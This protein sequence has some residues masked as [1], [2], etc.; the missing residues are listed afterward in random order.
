M[1]TLLLLAAASAAATPAATSASTSQ[2][3]ERISIYATRQPQRIEQVNASVNV[4][5]R[6]E[7]DMR[8]PK[9]LPAL[10]QSLPGVEVARQGSRGQT[11]SIFIRGSGSKYVLVLID[12]MRV[13]SATLGYMDLSQL[14]LDAIEQI[15][16]IRGPRAALYGSDAVSGV[17][18]ITT[19]KASGVTLSAKVASQGLAETSLQGA[20]TIDQTQL[21]AQ[22]GYGRA[23]GIHVLDKPGVDTDRD[24][25]RNRFVRSGLTQR[26]TGGDIS[27]QSQLNRGYNQFDFN[28][29]WGLGA[30]QAKT[31]QDQHQLSASYQT[32]VGTVLKQVSTQVK[33]GL[34]RDDSLTYGN[35]ASYRYIT[36]RQELDAQSLLAFAGD[37]DWLIGV[38]RTRDEVATSGDAYVRENR[39]S[40]SAFTAVS[41]Q[42][43]ALHLDTALRHDHVSA[44]DSYQTYQWGASYQ[45]TESL[46][47]R[48]NQGSS[49]KVPTYNDLYYP[50]FGN[51]DLQ[52]ET[53]LSREAGVRFTPQGKAQVTIDAVHFQRNLSNMIAY[54]SAVW[55]SQN[56]AAAELTGFEYT[57]A[58][59]TAL[60]G[61]DI[62]HEL[63]ATYTDGV[64]E[65]TKNRVLPNIP[66]QKYQYQFSTERG[67]WQYQG[68]LAYR[69]KVQSRATGKETVAASY[70]VNAGVAY[71][72]TP[73]TVVRLTIDNL[74]DRNYRTDGDY[75]QPGREFALSVQTTLF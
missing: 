72:W 46:Q 57:V 71:Q 6:D 1:S 43:A 73:T 9:D 66:K 39:V 42:L 68:R 4:I 7:I 18:A 12:G 41:W 62:Q 40:Q 16:L 25:F 31:R 11:S 63:L 27:W 15:E 36:K 8:Q 56:I 10:L 13:G 45:L 20:T 33:A 70:T 64:D 22:A 5:S 50:N 29:A 74:L 34:G 51:P 53:S 52:P 14:P 21:F 26:F 55:Q 23:D 35:G 30:D 19:R 37:I 54:N 38:N 67:D 65:V 28:P 58:F 17:I 3:I 59:V 44:Y 32:Q 2:P 47:A 48:V 75:F 60:G 61:A 69:D 24:G 49:F